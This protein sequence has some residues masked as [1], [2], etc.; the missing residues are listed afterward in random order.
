MYRIHLNWMSGILKKRKLPFYF[1]PL[2]VYGY[3]EVHFML[4]K[5]WPALKKKEYHGWGSTST[6]VCKLVFISSPPLHHFFFPS[7]RFLLRVWL[8]FFAFV[9]RLFPFVLY[10]IHSQIIISVTLIKH[11][12]KI[13]VVFAYHFSRKKKNM[14]RTNLSPLIKAQV[15]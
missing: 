10:L 3:R 15:K 11:Y 13:C 9:P 8:F 7:F 1:A 12:Q 5:I 2:H 6:Y 14:S 4:Q